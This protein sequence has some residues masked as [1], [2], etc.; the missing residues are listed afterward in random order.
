M[1][2]Q[3]RT[4]PVYEVGLR[5]KIGTIEEHVAVDLT[6]STVL[7]AN[8]RRKRLVTQDSQIFVHLQDATDKAKRV[9]SW[10]I[11][12]LQSDIEKMQQRL[13]GLGES[14]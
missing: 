9:L 2:Q 7:L 8:G 1:E 11:A 3:P 12:M 5:W 10:K 13:D 4:F 14:K 6:D